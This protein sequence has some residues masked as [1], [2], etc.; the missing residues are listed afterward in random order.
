MFIDY[1]YDVD[2]AVA[3]LN[4]LCTTPPRSLFAMCIPA[5]GNW[6]L[7][8][9]D[10]AGRHAMPIRVKYMHGMF[11]GCQAF[12]QRLSWDLSTV[13]GL[14]NM[15]GRGDNDKAADVFGSKYDKKSRWELAPWTMSAEEKWSLRKNYGLQKCLGLEERQTWH[16]DFT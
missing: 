13:A 16:A 9:K 8:N 11:Q 3:A 2:V 14:W 4:Q 15:F 10:L 5:I 6:K 1:N 7:S 12:D